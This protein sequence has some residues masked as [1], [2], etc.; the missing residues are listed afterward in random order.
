MIREHEIQ[1]VE[2]HDRGD[3][4]WRS[5]RRA[6]RP[7]ETKKTYLNDSELPSLYETLLE[8]KTSY[9]SNTNK[10]FIPLDKLELAG[11]REL[12]ERT[13]KEEGIL[14]DEVSI[15]SDKICYDQSTNGK[16]SFFRIFAILVLCEKVECIR[17]FVDQ[18]ID[19]ACL[20]LPTM[21]RSQGGINMLLHK[22]GPKV[23]PKKLKQLFQ[24]RKEWTQGLLNNFNTYQWWVIAPFFDRNDNTIPHYILEADDVL[25]F[26]EKKN[27]LDNMVESM[28]AEV[29]EAIL[30]GGFSD[31]FI[32]KIHQSHYSFRYQ[33][34]SDG[35]HSFA[36]KALKSSNTSEFRLEVEAH[37]KCNYGMEKHL[38]PLLA[39]IQKEEDD[40]DKYYLLFPKANGDL[41]HFWETK[42]SENSDRS[43]LRW[44]AEQCLGIA[45]ALSI[46]HQDQD[47][48]KKEDHPIYGRHGDVKA[49]NILWF[50]N[51]EIP[52]PAGW[53]LVLSDF[54]LMRFHRAISISAQTA[55]KLKKTLT[56]Q[57]PEFEIIGAKVSRKSDVWALGCTFLEFTTCYIRSYKAVDQEFPSCRGEDDRKLPGLSEDRFYRII[58]NG[59]RA[60]LKQGVREWISDL[61]HDPKCTSYLCDLLDFIEHKMLCIEIKE[62]PTAAEVADKLES[63]LPTTFQGEKKPRK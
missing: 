49:G 15:L 37:R 6:S 62:R 16:N 3:S 8:A 36:L 14:P 53:R 25:P 43:L 46:L 12:V 57:A 24:D 45:R 21:E 19:D 52:G 54:G 17:K 13:L 48:D 31:V 50:S 59:R 47:P 44:M 22:H 2:L 39:T 26:T 42:F 29:K 18:G 51:P 1:R 23:D 28:D 40:I 7:N 20:P 30:G 33:P 10:R 32:V 38:I 35:S 58:D 41:R 61:R 5:S 60:E 27:H 9:S 34:Y 63:L 56:Y 55:S 4:F 11:N